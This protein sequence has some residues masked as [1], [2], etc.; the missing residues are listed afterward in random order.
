MEGTSCKY[1]RIPYRLGEKHNCKAIIE[2]TD[3]EQKVERLET[4]LKYAKEYIPNEYKTL[5]GDIIDPDDF[6]ALKTTEGE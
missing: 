4:Q 1:C 3:L 6:K 5:N 2:I